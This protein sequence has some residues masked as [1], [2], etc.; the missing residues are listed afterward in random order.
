ML[1]DRYF[2]ALRR[3]FR[4]KTGDDFEELVQRTLI[5]CVE[6]QERFTGRGNFR[7]YLFGIAYNVL[8]E[9]VR[10]RHREEGRLAP[11]APISVLEAGL[12][13]P[14]SFVGLRREHRVL[15]EALRCLP[16]TDQVVLELFY[17]EQLS[18]GEIAEALDIPR[19]TVRSRL[20]IAKGRLRG[21]LDEL[22]RQAGGLKSTADDLDRWAADMRQRLG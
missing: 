7:S 9:H 22:T 21:H 6:G 20:R 5:R 3:F 1:F 12:P 18:S 8:R 19:G 17:W 15:L 16:L 10:G 13:G 2:M 14:A 4:N 11:Q